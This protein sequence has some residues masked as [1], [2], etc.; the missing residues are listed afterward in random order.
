MTKGGEAGVTKEG[1]AGMTRRGGGGMAAV[2]FV[3]FG[4]Y[5]SMGVAYFHGK[6]VSGAGF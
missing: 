3:F 6:W 4:V 5:M 2:L 1:E